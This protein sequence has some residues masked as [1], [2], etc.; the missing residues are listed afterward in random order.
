M[1]TKT[2]FSFKHKQ[3]LGMRNGVI[4]CCKG[5]NMVTLDPRLATV[6]SVRHPEPKWLPQMA[7]IL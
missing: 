2:Y 6:E 5:G 7:T 1:F 4:G 3:F